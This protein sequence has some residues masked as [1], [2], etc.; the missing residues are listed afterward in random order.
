M[1]NEEGTGY[2]TVHMTDEYIVPPDEA[3]RLD[4]GE[5]FVIISGYGYKV[6]VAP[7]RVDDAS[8]RAAQD[9]IKQETTLSV[10]ASTQATSH[11]SEHNTERLTRANDASQ[12]SQKDDKSQQNGYDAP[13]RL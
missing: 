11:S 9:F 10:N 4:M 3:R 2:G 7:I 5:C 6:H 12:D 13:D 8:L 1:H